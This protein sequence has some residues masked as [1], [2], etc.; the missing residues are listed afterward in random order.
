MGENAHFTHSDTTQESG[1]KSPLIWK[2]LRRLEGGV[3]DFDRGLE[4][5]LASVAF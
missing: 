4:D 1:A 5:E 3:V 2:F